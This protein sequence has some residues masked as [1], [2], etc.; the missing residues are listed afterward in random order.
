[1]AKQIIWSLLAQEDRKSIFNYWNNRNK[2]NSYSRK[3][4]QLFKLTVILISK[5]PNIGKPTDIENV[6][7][8]IIRDFF[9]TYRITDNSIEILTIWSTRQDPQKFEEII[10]T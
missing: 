10:N 7:I 2:S 8:R 9:F 3:L 4:N 5:H 1:M 6:R